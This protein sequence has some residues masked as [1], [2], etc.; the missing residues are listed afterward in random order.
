MRFI[1]NHGPSFDNSLIFRTRI[2]IGHFHADVSCVLA[3]EL[4][5]M[6]GIALTAAWDNQRAQVDPC[7]SDQVGF[8]VVIE[9]GNLYLIVVGRIVHGK[10]KLLVPVERLALNCM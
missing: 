4:E 8:L 10:S 6:P 2:V 1:R 7:F 3:L 9:D 5:F